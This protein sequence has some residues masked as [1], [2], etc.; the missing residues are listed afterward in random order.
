MLKWFIAFLV[1]ALCLGGAAVTLA[2]RLKAKPPAW[3]TENVTRGKLVI[4]VTAT[5]TVGP[6]QTLL[7][8]S[9]IS[10]RVKTVEKVA[11]D[12]IKKGDVLALLDT[13]LLDSEKR[14]ADVRLLQAR[15]ALSQLKVERENLDIRRLRH[16]SA[17]ERKKISIQRAK[18]TLELASKNLKR[19]KDL[20][21]VDAAPQSDYDIRELEESNTR[22]DLRL[23][24]IDLEQSSVDMQQIDA[25]A[26]QL[27]AREEQAGADIMQAESQLARVVTS[28]KYASIIS[29][30]DGV[31]LQHL[32]EPGQT[33]AASFQTPNLFKLA[34][35]LRL[36]RID[37]QLDEADVG[38]IISGQ[39]VTFDVDAY[40]NDAFTGKVA[41]VRIQSESKGNLV[42]YPV[43]V[44]ASNIPKEPR[45]SKIDTSKSV[46]SLKG[47][48]STIS[49]SVQAEE[50]K[51]L[52]GMTA[53]LKFVVDQ[54]ENVV[55]LPNAALRFIPPLG[56][57]PDKLPEVKDEKK[58]R[59]GTK[60][61]V[62]ITNALGLLDRRAVTV[63]ENDGEN[64]ELLEGDIK[65]GDAIVTGTK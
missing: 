47:L 34:T 11:N 6:I 7:I 32:I 16:A 15:A 12:L 28:L 55:L 38:R 13:E 21:A 45:I 25:D 22:H 50:W 14:G 59:K 40:R 65:E 24:E 9:Q 63:G 4:T 57:A 27:S 31:V 19:I 37:A 5:G 49:T 20:I 53:N 42:T 60:G 18:G 3:K 56:M 46:A 8:G 54:R 41:L 51:L 1:F 35:D 33:I 52:P 44:Q 23:Q 43:L 64:F 26:K 29:P 58:V 39:D 17:I 48:P 2:P 30:I 36:I 62:F 61:S 10:G